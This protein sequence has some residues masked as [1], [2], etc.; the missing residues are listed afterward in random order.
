MLGVAGLTF[1][2]SRS[3]LDWAYA[4]TAAASAE[5]RQSLTLAGILCSGVAAWV[6]SRVSSPRLAYSPAGA[7]RR[8]HRL[9]LQQV[10][11]IGSA[12]FIGMI[13]GLLPTT[14]WA[15][16]G[17]EFGKIDFGV[18][19]SGFASMLSFVSAGYLLGVLF[20]PVV[21]VPAATALG[22]AWVVFSG[23]DGRVTSPV[24][25]FDVEAGLTEPFGVTL[26]RIVYFLTITALLIAAASW[27]LQERDVR[28][29]PTGP[30]GVAALLVTGLGVTLITN[31]HHYDL[32]EKNPSSPVCART[33]S[34]LE[35]CVHAA[36]ADLVTELAQHVEEIINV[37]GPGAVGISE[38]ADAALWRDN[39]PERVNLQ[40]QTHDS[41][42]WLTVAAADVASAIAGLPVCYSAT[43]A[44]EATSRAAASSAVAAWILSQIGADSSMVLQSPEAADTYERLANMP[45][46]VVRQGLLRNISDFRSCN[47]DLSEL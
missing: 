23:A 17:A 19:L 27:W 4:D 25:P 43:G 41:E 32:V 15:I 1:I 46:A 11:E 47:I 18:M 6:G 31:S 3:L 7:H 20:N 40:L 26:T 10:A 42:R 12:S 38:V 9:A 8:G 29:E 37:L 13:L 14:I 21:A 39:A 2:H 28:L 30:A 35:V 33:D 45:A 24:W 44:P 16:F 34:D 22:F 36:R 5:Y